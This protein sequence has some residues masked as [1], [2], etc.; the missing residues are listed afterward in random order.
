[1][2]RGERRKEKKV[3]AVDRK[4]NVNTTDEFLFVKSFSIEKK[5]LANPKANEV[6]G[7]CLRYVGLPYVDYVVNSTLGIM[8]T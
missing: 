3:E 2:R 4:Q 7:I 1:L 5:N 6:N 8:T